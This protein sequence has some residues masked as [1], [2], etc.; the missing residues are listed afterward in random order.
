MLSGKTIFMIRIILFS[1]T[2]FP[3]TRYDRREGAQNDLGKMENEALRCL[4]LNSEDA[5]MKITDRL[6]INHNN[7]RFPLRFGSARD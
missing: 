1:G 7:L 2:F 5:Y 6:Q 4:I 3:F